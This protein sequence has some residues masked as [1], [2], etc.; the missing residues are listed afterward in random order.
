MVYNEAAVNNVETVSDR[1]FFE[2]ESTL[3]HDRRDSGPH[4][5]PY[6]VDSIAFGTGRRMEPREATTPAAI[7]SGP[8]TTTYNGRRRRDLS[9]IVGSR[10]CARERAVER[11]VQIRSAARFDTEVAEPSEDAEERFGP[12]REGMNSS[13]RPPSPPRPPCSMRNSKTHDP[14]TGAPLGERRRVFA[15]QV[16]ARREIAPRLGPAEAGAVL[17]PLKSSDYRPLRGASMRPDRNRGTT[18]KCG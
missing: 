18:A 15:D 3:C 9:S 2:P 5:G 6:V 7:R 14:G 10:D 8:G 16:A 4:R 17:A 12:P 13:P 1:Q 11:S